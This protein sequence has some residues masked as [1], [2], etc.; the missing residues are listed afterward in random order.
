MMCRARL[1]ALLMSLVAIAPARAEPLPLKV[2]CTQALRTRL[3]EL[4]PR[5]EQASGTKIELNIAPSGKLVARVR[6]G[7]TADVL[8]ANAPNIDALIKEGKVAGAR[9]D[10]ARADVGLAVRAGS[11][12]P[13]I[14]SVEG[15]KRA[16]LE[17]GAVAY[18]PGGL[19]GVI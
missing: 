12:K 18:S 8:I 11:P 5:F 10:L 17:A 15:V 4:A 14:S 6:D 7:E 2:L 3:L 13:D 1:A 19:S 16:L 9:I